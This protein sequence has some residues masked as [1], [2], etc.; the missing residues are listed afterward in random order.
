[1]TTSAAAAK[2][3]GVHLKLDSETLD[4]ITERARQARPG[5]AL[6]ALAGGLLFAAGWL[7]AR[8]FRILFFSGAWAWAAMAV[9][10]RQARGEPSRGPSAEQLLAENEALRK[11]LARITPVM[12]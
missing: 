4:V 2:A 3:A 10:W 9:G 1:M 6:L 11:E 12:S 5:R 7:A 8:A